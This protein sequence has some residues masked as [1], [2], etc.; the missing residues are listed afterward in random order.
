ME[1]M[2]WMHCQAC[3]CPE[4]NEWQD[5]MKVPATWTCACPKGNGWQDRIKVPATWTCAC[6]EGNGWQDRIKVPATWPSC[7]GKL[8]NARTKLVTP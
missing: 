3:A 1:W 6:P 4:G 8:N 5:R 7:H 2:D